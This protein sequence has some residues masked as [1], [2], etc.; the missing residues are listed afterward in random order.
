[1]KAIGQGLFKVRHS[2]G[3]QGV[4]WVM[5]QDA[6]Q[7]SRKIPKGLHYEGMR[8]GDSAQAARDTSDRYHA[9]SMRQNEHRFCLIDYC[10]PYPPLEVSVSRIGAG[11]CERGTVTR[12]TLDEGLNR[13]AE[14]ASR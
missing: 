6:S 5:K 7:V 14:D 1:M 8:Q 10:A 4:G 12:R 3:V 11:S 9:C 13:I 2:E